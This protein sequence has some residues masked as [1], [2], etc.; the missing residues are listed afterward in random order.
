MV[1]QRRHSRRFDKFLRAGAI[2]VAAIFHPLILKIVEMTTRVR[3][4]GRLCDQCAP[5]VTTMPDV[6]R[7]ALSLRYGSV[8]GV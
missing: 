3:S 1:T 5:Y 4:V 2:P 7:E 8:T 6:R